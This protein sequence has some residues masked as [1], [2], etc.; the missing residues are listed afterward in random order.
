MSTCELLS[1]SCHRKYAKTHFYSLIGLFKDPKHVYCQVLSGAISDAQH[2]EATG[3]SQIAPYSLFSALLLTI[4][5]PK[6]LWSKVVHYIGNLVLFG[7]NP[8]SANC[9]EAHGMKTQ[10][11]ILINILYI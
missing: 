8:T 6:G 9:F 4:T 7:T 1:Y 5:A 3:A 2:F 10:V 11:E